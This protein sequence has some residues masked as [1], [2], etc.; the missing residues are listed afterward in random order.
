MLNL[1]GICKEQLLYYISVP[2]KIWNTRCWIWLLIVILFPVKEA[3]NT[4]GHIECKEKQMAMVACQSTKQLIITGIWSAVEDLASVSRSKML[5]FNK[6]RFC[7]SFFCR[8][9][10][11]KPTPC[12]TDR[13][14]AVVKCPLII[15]LW[16]QAKRIKTFFIGKPI[17]RQTL[18]GMN[19]GEAVFPFAVMNEAAWDIGQLFA[20]RKSSFCSSYVVIRLPRRC[21]RSISPDPYRRPQQRISDSI[22]CHGNIWTFDSNGAPSIFSGRS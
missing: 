19:I 2:S 6:E 14:D 16:Y 5:H 13:R 10:T 18:Q 12:T 21:A 4:V 1:S 15:S 20:T 9:A 3:V 11:C 22:S 7:L 17:V 8:S